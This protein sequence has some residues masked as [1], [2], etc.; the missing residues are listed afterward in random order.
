MSREIG[1]GT[2]LYW[3]AKSGLRSGAVV[4]PGD[5]RTHLMRQVVIEV[6]TGSPAVTVPNAAETGRAML[7]LAWE[8]VRQREFP[9]RPSRFECLFLWP[10]ASAARRFDSHRE[11]CE[12]YD[13]EILECSRA[14][15]ADMNLISYFEASETLASMFERARRYWQAERKDEHGEILL[16]G[17]IRIQGTI[18]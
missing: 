13:V 15:A 6:Q 8:T 3:S 10:E 11:A 12:L 18:S 7:E 5:F 9:N 1:P 14:F 2:H 16:E 4:S 17:T